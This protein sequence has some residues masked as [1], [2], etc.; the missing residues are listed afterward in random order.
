MIYRG[1]ALSIHLSIN[2]RLQSNGAG[3][4]RILINRRG[5]NIPI[6]TYKADFKCFFLDNV[7]Q[8]MASHVKETSLNQDMFIKTRRKGLRT[9]V[10]V[11]FMT[12]YVK[13]V[14]EI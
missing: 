5:R 3:L 1:I 10:S 4:D 8:G 11:V 6:Y 12:C 2:W 13:N 14:L 7:H 9:E